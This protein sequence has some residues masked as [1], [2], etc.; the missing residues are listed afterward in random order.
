M[1]DHIDKALAAI[2]DA[3]SGYEGQHSPE[4]EMYSDVAPVIPEFA[5]YRCLEGLPAGD[6]DL[7]E[8]C[9]DYLLGDTTLDPRRVSGPI[10]YQ[11]IH[12]GSMVRDVHPTRGESMG[13]HPSSWLPPIGTLTE[14]EL[15]RLVG[16]PIGTLTEQELARLVNRI[17]GR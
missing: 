12:P 7:C 1:S 17:F 13:A 14:Q 9:R 5:C 4:A 8:P 11:P 10:H 2:D 3:L 6:S 16:R 15:A